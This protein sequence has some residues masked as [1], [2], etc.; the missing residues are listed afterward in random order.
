MIK[1]REKAFKHYFYFMEQRMN[2]FWARYNNEEYPWTDDPILLRHKF[3]NVY[4]S[5]D[6]ASQY[7]IQKVIYGQ[8]A[9]NFSEEDTLLRILLFKI[10]NK[11][12][13]WEYL[14]SNLGEI[15]LKN[16]D[17][18]CMSRLLSNRITY[19]PIFSAAYL[20]T[21]SHN[22]YTQY[23]S[24]HERWLQMVNRKFIKEKL[25]SKIIKSKS[26]EEIFIILLSCPFIGNFLAYQYVIDFNYSE[27]I[28]FDEN[29]FV[30]AGIGA[31]RGLRKCF[32]DSGGSSDEDLIRYTHNNIEKYR[33]LY[34]YSDFKNLFGR[35]PTLIDLQ[36]CFCET[37]KYL[38]VKMPELR[39]D[40]IRIKQIYRQNNDNINYFFPPKWGINNKIKN[41]C[42]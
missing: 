22:D 20:M 11:I 14:E 40:N 16:F 34:D 37:D 31:I 41:K 23:P 8:N 39:V 1:V 38:R 7:L 4:R 9:K 12:D 29:S 3:T 2:I 10:F 6:R 32:E 35:E 18:D 24:K 28:N 5:C 19:R 21:G 27:I 25:F 36:N 30:K 17:V 15:S 33:V 26:L 13:T 42:V